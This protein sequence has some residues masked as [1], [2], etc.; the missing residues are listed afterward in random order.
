MKIAAYILLVSF[1]MTS[2]FSGVAVAEGPQCS[3]LTH[4]PKYMH[5]GSPE[6]TPPSKIYQFEV[7]RADIIANLQDAEKTKC[8]NDFYQAGL[9][10]EATYWTDR[11]PD[12]CEISNKG[13]LAGTCD[14]DDEAV[15]SITFTSNLED[16]SNAEI[17]AAV[18]A[19]RA[20]AEEENNQAEVSADH[21]ECTSSP[22]AL[23]AMAEANQNANCCGTPSDKGGLVRANQPNLSYHECLAATHRT[24]KAGYEAAPACVLSMVVGGAK[25]ILDSIVSLVKLPGELI[26]ARAN[27][28]PYDERGSSC[29]ICGSD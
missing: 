17:K 12:G 22:A 6:G 20:A 15:K 24:N 3:E 28:E 11:L 21:P 5:S 7:I 19:S 26:G 9:K 10:E 8:L 1:V 18:A 27:L 23:A 2:A 29:S 25:A 4:T 16:D 14:K 13:R